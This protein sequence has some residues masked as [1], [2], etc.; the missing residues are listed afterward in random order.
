M[1]TN[2]TSYVEE[3]QALKVEISEEE[4]EEGSEKVVKVKKDDD[5]IS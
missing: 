5:D 3:A 2:I 1:L 4:S